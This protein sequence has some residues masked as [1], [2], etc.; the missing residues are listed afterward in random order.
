MLLLKRPELGPRS[1]WS[2]DPEASRLFYVLL[3]CVGVLG[4]G[5][6]L[7]FILRLVPGAAEERLGVLEPLPPDVGR[8]RTDTDSSEGRA[9]L[10]RGQRREERLYFEEGKGLFG[11]GKLW[12]QVRYRNMHDNAIVHVEPDLH[13]KRRRIRKE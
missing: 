6:Y 11:A 10:E 7:T 4:L 13:V 3:S 5:I 9:A 1:G 12:R 2:S 8:W